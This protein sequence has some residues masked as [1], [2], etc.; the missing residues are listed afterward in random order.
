MNKIEE[1]NYAGG[2]GVEDTGNTCPVLHLVVASNA[3]GV[4]LSYCQPVSW[5]EMP[6]ESALAL[7]QKLIDAGNMALQLQ[8]MET[9]TH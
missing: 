3:E 6:A 8:Q 4:L 9:V 2:F 5:I 7:G 1:Q